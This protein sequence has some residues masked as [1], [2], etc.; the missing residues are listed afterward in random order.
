M[1]YKDIDKASSV[2]NKLKDSESATWYWTKMK[3]IQTVPVM[4]VATLLKKKVTLEKVL[5]SLDDA[6][7]GLEQQQIIENEKV[8]IE[9][10]KLMK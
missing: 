10:S 9:K 7:K 3:W 4:M 2:V 6:I 5:S 1:D 8:I